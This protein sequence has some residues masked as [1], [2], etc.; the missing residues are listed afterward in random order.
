MAFA[1]VGDRVIPEEGLDQFLVACCFAS[2]LP[3]ERNNLVTR[4]LS[5]LHESSPVS[6]SREKYL[7]IASGIGGGSADRGADL[8]AMRI[9]HN[10]KI[11]DTELQHMVKELGADVPARV[12]SRSVVLN[13][14]DGTTLTSAE[15]LTMYALLVNSGAFVLTG[16]VF[17]RFYSMGFNGVLEH[18]ADIS[19]L[20]SYPRKKVLKKTAFFFRNYPFPAGY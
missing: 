12:R 15:L 18:C 14:G 2:D 1:D 4:A 6:V 16:L 5:L 19:M 9:F 8:R 13:G 11:S 20:S 17:R 7:P 3:N 10:W